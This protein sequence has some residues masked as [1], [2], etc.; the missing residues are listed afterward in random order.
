MSWYT[1]KRLRNT[2]NIPN[3]HQSGIDYVNSRYIRA[4]EIIMSFTKDEDILYVTTKMFKVHC[5]EKK[6][7]QPAV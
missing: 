6:N 1:V 5:A 2:G 3:I 7:K 4:I